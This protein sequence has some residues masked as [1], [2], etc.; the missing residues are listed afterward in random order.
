MLIFLS[1]N[2]RLDVMAFAIGAKV[3]HKIQSERDY[4]FDGALFRTLIHYGARYRR[5]LAF[6]SM[7][8]ST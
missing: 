7:P 8:D 5:R 4:P 3:L 1:G 6:R 2:W